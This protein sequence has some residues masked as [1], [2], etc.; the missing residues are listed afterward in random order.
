MKDHNDHLNNKKINNKN[1]IL[2]SKILVTKTL[3]KNTESKIIP[4]TKKNVT[5]WN[6]VRNQKK[7]RQTSNTKHHWL[8]DDIWVLKK[9]KAEGCFTQTIVKSH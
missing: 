5:K 6:K 4:R 3:K 9:G 7:E 2:K 8:D 1:Y